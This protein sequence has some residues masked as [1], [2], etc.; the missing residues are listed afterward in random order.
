MMAIESADV[1]VPLRGGPAV[2]ISVF[3]WM[4]DAEERGLRFT[5]K[6]DG[7]LF[8]GPRASTREDDLTF[9]RT[10]RDVVVAVVKYCDEARVQ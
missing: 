1:L 3:R 10:H 6:P 5:L 4:L 7:S 2:P 9:I 8:V